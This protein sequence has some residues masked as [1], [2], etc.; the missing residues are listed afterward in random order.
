MNRERNYIN[1]INSLV[2]ALV[3]VADQADEREAAAQAGVGAET[4]HVHQYGP[5]VADDSHVYISLCGAQAIACLEWGQ[6]GACPREAHDH[7]VCMF[8]A[9]HDGR[10][11]WQVQPHDD[12]AAT[13]PHG[14][15]GTTYELP[16]RPQT[17]RRVIDSGGV[18]WQSD[19]NGA[20]RCVHSPER[21][22][23]M[24]ETECTCG[25]TYPIPWYL[26]TTQCAIRVALQDIPA[27]GDILAWSA[28]LETRGRVALVPLTD[29]EKAGEA[30]YGPLG[31][32][33]AD[34][35]GPACP[36]LGGCALRTGHAGGHVDR[37]GDPCPLTEGIDPSIGE[38][39]H[40]ECTCGHPSL[41][42]PGCPRDP[43]RDGGPGSLVVVW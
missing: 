3:A 25:A 37:Q 2:K 21:I 38:A 8:V 14:A 24:E 26:H 13:D 36:Y 12:R 33:W 22:P 42:R 18:V 16:G 9:H 17:E 28:L 29:D 11:S 6:P 5:V 4:I 10:H 23:T 30:L 7:D 19:P 20:M 35:N 1:I 43:Y 27:P 15:G 39:D 34:P 32:R 40:T 31:A 41:H